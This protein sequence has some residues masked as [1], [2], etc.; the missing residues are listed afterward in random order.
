VAFS[1]GRQPFLTAAFLT[2]FQ[3]KG[4]GTGYE[5]FGKDEQILQSLI[6]LSPC[7]PFD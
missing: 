3:L 6:L 1:R 2:A 5:E 4:K 7:L